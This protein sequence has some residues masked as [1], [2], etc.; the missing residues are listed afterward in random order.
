MRSILILFAIAVVGFTFIIQKKDAPEV[1][2][3][4]ATSAAVNRMGER[5]WATRA[6]VIDPTREVAQNRARQR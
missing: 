3:A 4:K 2:P 5:S 6:L 1:R